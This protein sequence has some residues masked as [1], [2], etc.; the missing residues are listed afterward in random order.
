MSVRKKQP[1]I[2]KFSGGLTAQLLALMSAI[3][4]SGKLDRPF[5]MKYFP[6]STGTYWPLGIASILEVSEL[7]QISKT[8][9]VNNKGDL[10]PGDYI[11]DFPLRRTGISYERFLQIIHRLHLDVALRWLR[12]EYVIGARI[13]RLRKVP[14]RARTVSGN[15]PPIL[16][17]GVI[18]ELSRRVNRANLPNPFEIQIVKKSVVIHYRLGDMRKMP[19]R[20]SDYGGHG[21]VDPS[22]FREIVDSKNIEHY[23]MRIKVVSDEPRIATKLLQ[24]VG[25]ADV[26]D[27]S[28]GNVWQDLQTIASAEIFIGSSSQ[29][30]A[31]G[32]ILCAKNGGQVILPASNY[33]VGDS[34][35]DMGVEEFSYFEYRYLKASHWIFEV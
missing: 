27:V 30:S 29:F 3:Y 19:A 18:R 17:S 2:I 28:S 10:N 11:A 12:G 16:D 34:K 32:A 26:E 8:R 23:G 9:G 13:S 5:K 33:G 25:F 4:L 24:E 20:N 22:V 21:V 35:R 14:K 7:E 6:Y 1:L 31:F 15:F